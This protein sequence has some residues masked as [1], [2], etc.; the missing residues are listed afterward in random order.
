MKN[1][2]N[3]LKLLLAVL[4]ISLAI[5]GCKKDIQSKEIIDEDA[6]TSAR[7]VYSSRT[8]DFTHSDGA[9][10]KATATA[11]MG[12]IIGNWQSG[13][14]D[15]SNNQV[16]VRIPA[17][18]ISSNPTAAGSGNTVQIDVPDGSEYELSFKVRFGSDFQWS[19][20]GKTGFGFLIGD[21]FTGCNKADSGTGGSARIMWYNPTNQKD[22]SGTDKPFFRPYVYYKDMPDDCGNNFGK[23]SKQLSKN[24]WYTIKIRVKSNT[25]SDF[26]GQ[27]TYDVDGVNLLSKNDI[28]W[29]TDTSKRL[30]KVITFHTFRGGSQDY[31]SSASDGLI[32]YDDLSWTRLAS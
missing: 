6:V 9:Y 20:G 22:N 26:N 19:R 8:V 29:T 31:W 4:G 14:V 21:G 32:Y 28:R 30:I 18:S 3:K 25:G 27:I 24:T 12:D 23:Q 5:A 7:A 13:N 1:N 16:R 15:I 2:F 11:D 17:N 10:S